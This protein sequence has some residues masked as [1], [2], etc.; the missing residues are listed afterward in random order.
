[1]A[2]KSANDDESEEKLRWAFKMFDTDSSGEYQKSVN[3]CS[4]III[5]MYHQLKSKK[6]SF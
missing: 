2:T 4:I 5:R 6:T 3:E 1:M